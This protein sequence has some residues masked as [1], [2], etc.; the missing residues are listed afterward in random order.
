[1]S[2]L[3][4]ALICGLRTGGGRVLGRSNRL[5]SELLDVQHDLQR[6][7]ESGDVGP[8]DK[9]SLEI[10]EETIGDFIDELEEEV[11]KLKRF[12]DK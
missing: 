12:Y 6:E 8:E 2:N 10:Y 4:K 7:I 9:K 11:V 3:V 5:I 1:M